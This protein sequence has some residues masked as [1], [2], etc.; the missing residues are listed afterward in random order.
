MKSGDDSVDFLYTMDD[1]RERLEDMDKPVPDERYEDIILQALPAE[2]EKARTVSY[3][4]RYFSRGRHS[5]HDECLVHQLSF[6]SEQ[7]SLGAGRGVAMQATGGDDSTIK[8]HYCGNSGHRQKNCV[9]WIVAQCKGGKPQTTR[10]TPLGSWKR[11][12]GG[13]SKPR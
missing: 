12:T 1:F 11:K 10:S 2:Y 3:E 13:D 4:R 6:P 9:A 7:L 8:Y 5:A